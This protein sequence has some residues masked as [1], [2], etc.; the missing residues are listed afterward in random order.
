[1]SM[2]P[3]K[4]K[5]KR[6]KDVIPDLFHRTQLS[7]FLPAKT[8]NSRS[9]TFESA[10]APSASSSRPHTQAVSK[11]QTIAL[12]PEKPERDDHYIV[13]PRDDSQRSNLASSIFQSTFKNTR[14]SATSE[15]SKI[16]VDTL[17]FSQ[18]KSQSLNRSL[19]Q[20]YGSIKKQDVRAHKITS[21]FNS[22]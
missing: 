14:Q 12:T 20:K 10:K 15:Q 2:V 7:H 3:E 16:P 19:L 6:P 8:Y 9:C 18:L 4:I 1:M 21:Y 5:T 11:R 17:S 13:K 22:A